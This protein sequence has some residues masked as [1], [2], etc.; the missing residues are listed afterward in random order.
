[1]PDENKHL[2]G[3][4]VFNFGIWSQ[5]KTICSVYVLNPILKQCLFFCALSFTFCNF[6]LSTFLENLS[7]K[8]NTV[9]NC[10]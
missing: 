2:R 7:Q 5:V 8:V 10:T 6:N 9:F 3:S 1:M 4:L